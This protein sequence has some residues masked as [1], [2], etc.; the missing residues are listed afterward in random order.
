ML[1][2]LLLCITQLMAQ[3]QEPPSFWEDEFKNEFNREPMHATYFA[4]ENKDLALKNDPVE[5]KYFQSLNG[6]LEI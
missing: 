3:S 4:F 6:E 1:P 2:V 5:S